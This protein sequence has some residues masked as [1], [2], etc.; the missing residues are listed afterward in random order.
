MN[1]PLIEF[2]ISGA[3]SALIHITGG[4]D[5]TLNEA[6][7]AADLVTEQMD[8][9]AMVIWGA[10]VDPNLTGTV[11]IM[12]LI[13]GVKSPQVLGSTNSGFIAKQTG[14]NPIKSQPNLADEFFN[15]TELKSINDIA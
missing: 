8:E 15:I 10:R 12:L 2:D 3:K 5:L 11:R 6:T 7:K 9:N 1:S 13:V 14:K 4:D